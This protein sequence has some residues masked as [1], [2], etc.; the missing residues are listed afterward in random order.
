MSTFPAASSFVQSVMQWVWPKHYMVLTL[1]AL[2]EMVAEPRAV[3]AAR[4]VVAVT[5]ADGPVKA[6]DA[7]GAVGAALALTWSLHVK[8][9]RASASA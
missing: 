8:M 2:D 3:A 6:S 9:I 5:L 7:L 1:R 4:R